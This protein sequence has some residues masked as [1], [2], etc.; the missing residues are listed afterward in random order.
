MSFYMGS[1]DIAAE[2]TAMEISQIL[3]RHGASDILTTYEGKVAVGLSFR[4]TNGGKPM[5]FRLPIR[6]D[7]VLIA[8]KADKGRRRYAVT[9]E[10]AGRTAWRL[11]LRWVQAQLALVEVGAVSVEEVFLP[12]AHTKS[13]A[14][15][16]E[17]FQQNGIALLSAPMGGAG[18]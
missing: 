15:L 9:I 5:S 13:G 17:H 3:A 1:T 14:T 12:Y 11:I 8:M 2:K 6:A 7:K 16:Y 4:I 10:Q 18:G